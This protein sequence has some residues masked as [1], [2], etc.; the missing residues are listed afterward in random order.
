MLSA[1][2]SSFILGSCYLFKLHENQICWPNV[3]VWFTLYIHPGIVDVMQDIEGSVPTEGHQGEM[4][5]DI[6]VQSD[7]TLGTPTHIY[8]T[9]G[10]K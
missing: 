8:T 4:P 6:D 3:A 10:L 7:L 5:L 2:K 9:A 1:V